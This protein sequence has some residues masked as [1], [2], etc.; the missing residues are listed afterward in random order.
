MSMDVQFCTRPGPRSA[1]IY[2][3]RRGGIT[4]RD[5][6]WHF[7]SDAELYFLQSYENKCCISSGFRSVLG[8]RYFIPGEMRRLKN[9]AKHGGSQRGAFA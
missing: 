9:M 8:F 2:K 6:R 4:A 1:G 7:G 5:V 3:N